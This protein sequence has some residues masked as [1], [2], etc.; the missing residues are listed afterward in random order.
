MILKSAKV[1]IYDINRNILLLTR[2]ETHPKYAHQLDLPGGLVDNDESFELTIK[3]ECLEEIGLDISVEDLKLVKQV[4]FPHISR[5]L[6]E[7]QLSKIKP[8][9]KLSWEH[10]EYKW[11]SEEEIKKMKTS[12]Q[13][14]P[15]FNM[16]IDYLN[17]K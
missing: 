6:F 17:K 11:F 2:S 1:I 4:R 10:S 13:Y 8:D 5:N 15:Y 9:I 14:D 16:L 7:I 3:R 12:K